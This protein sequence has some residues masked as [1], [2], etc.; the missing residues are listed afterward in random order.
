MKRMRLIVL[1]ATLLMFM[2]CACTESEQTTSSSEETT[3]VGDTITTN[4]YKP[5]PN[6]PKDLDPIIGKKIRED[7]L[8]Y[9]NARF[10][11]DPYGAA[12]EDIENIWIRYYKNFSF[13]ALVFMEDPVSQYTQALK[14]EMIAGY[15]FV[16]PSSQPLLI[17]VDSTFYR[18]NEAYESGKITKENVKKIYDEYYRKYTHLREEKIL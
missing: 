2:L 6:D 13:G 15:E 9:L 12:P 10:Q 5:H 16:F 14:H 17:H 18:I 4:A 1:A 11:N 3:T 8:D 7:Y